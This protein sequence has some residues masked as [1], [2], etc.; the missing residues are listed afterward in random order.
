MF[1]FCC[2]LAD[3]IESDESTWR[4][5]YDLDAPEEN[6]LPMGYDTFLNEFEKLLVLRCL[7]MDR[8]TVGITKFVI[9][10]MTEKYVQPPVL[11][12]YNIFKQ[13]TET[14]PIVFVLSPGKY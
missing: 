1:A 12:Y 5:Y 11:D 13:S 6:P 9:S 2:R 8:V 3:D 10:V 14:T 4:Q 7:R